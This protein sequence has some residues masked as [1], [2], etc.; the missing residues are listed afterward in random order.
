MRREAHTQGDNAKTQAASL[1]A[2]I[3]AADSAR[4]QPHASDL[5]AP[6]RHR[7]ATNGDRTRREAIGELATRSNARP[8]ETRRFGVTGRRTFYSDETLVLRNNWNGGAATAASPPNSNKLL[9]AARIGTLT[10]GTNVLG[11]LLHNPA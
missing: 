3:V 6:T 11:M 4:C 10:V 8:V 1:T 5:N 9:R 7:T 2:G